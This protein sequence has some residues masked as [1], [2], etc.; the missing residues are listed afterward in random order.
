MIFRVSSVPSVNRWKI[1]RKGIKNHKWNKH[2]SINEQRVLSVHQTRHW[3]R[4][5]KC[6]FECRRHD[7]RQCLLIRQIQ[8]VNSAKEGLK[9]RIIIWFM[10]LSEV[11]YYLQS[12]VAESKDFLH[13]LVSSQQKENLRTFVM[14]RLSNMINKSFLLNTCYFG[15]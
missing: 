9:T 11:G 6:I 7:V 12:S 13:F 4:F 15:S 14:H 10:N 2:K 8:S 3:F 5:K 1:N